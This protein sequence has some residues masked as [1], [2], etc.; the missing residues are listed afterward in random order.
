MHPP[1][2][3][4]RGLE[5]AVQTFVESSDRR[6]RTPKS[7]A[8]PEN[9]DPAKYGGLAVDSPE[10]ANRWRWLQS[11]ANAGPISE[12]VARVLYVYQL[13]CAFR[14]DADCP[15][16]NST[17]LY[18]PTLPHAHTSASTIWSSAPNE[19]LRIPTQLR[20]AVRI[21]ASRVR[22]RSTGPIQ[23]A[24]KGGHRS[25]G[26][27]ATILPS[28]GRCRAFVRTERLRILSQRTAWAWR[29]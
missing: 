23:G 18:V 13:L 22:Q 24:N 26:V 1:S 28:A 17:H 15:L 29:R 14:T 12:E 7:D 11:R 20:Q 3:P 16:R 4:W 8:D 2:S 9:G 19:R 5:A 10:L 21:R 25:P 6:C 27:M